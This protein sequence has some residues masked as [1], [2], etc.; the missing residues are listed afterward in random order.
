MVDIIHAEHLQLPD[1]RIATRYDVSPGE[2][3]ATRCLALLGA[4]TR[5]LLVG[6]GHLLRG[7]GRVLPQDDGFAR[8]DRVFVA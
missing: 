5:G 3:R 6:G 1:P 2:A 8:D 7:F 4:A